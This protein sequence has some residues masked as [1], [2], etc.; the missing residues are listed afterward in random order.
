MDPARILPSS[1]QVVRVPNSKIPPPQQQLSATPGTPPAATSCKPGRAK[2]LVAPSPS[3][4]TVTPVAGQVTP[5]SR[6]AAV[7]KSQS[8]GSSVIQTTQQ[9]SEQHSTTS[10]TTCTSKSTSSNPHTPLSS[11]ATDLTPVP[12]TAPSSVASSCS[13]TRSTPSLSAPA[14]EFHAR[15]GRTS[16]YA[17]KDS[18]RMFGVKCVVDFERIYRYLS[19]IH[20]QNEE[21]HLTPMGESQIHSLVSS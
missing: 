4:Q 18:P 7:I 9:L 8:V 14:A 10:S 17:T 12:I 15:F 6:P 11:S 20:K 16:K 2:I 19:V 3:S 13:S 21:C 5:G 1:F